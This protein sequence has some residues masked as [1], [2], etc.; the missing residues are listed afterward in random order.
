VVT[1][2]DFITIIGLAFGHWFADFVIQSRKIAE[3]KS[4]SLR[5]LFTHVGLYTTALACVMGPI[6]I[7]EHSWRLVLSFILLN[8][9]CH[10]VTDFATSKMSAHAWQSEDKSQFWNI[11]GFD[12]SIHWSHLLI[13]YFGFFV[14]G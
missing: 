4:S 13:T 5:S 7:R 11:I 12:Q 8:G 14:W 3:S 9:F 10:L 6:L 2:M 1:K